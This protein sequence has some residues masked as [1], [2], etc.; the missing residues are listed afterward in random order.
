MSR[1]LMAEGNSSIYIAGL[2]QRIAIK[3]CKASPRRVTAVTTILCPSNAGFL[4][5][6]KNAII[7]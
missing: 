2:R 4:S 7:P 1:L 3:D 6:T 5:N